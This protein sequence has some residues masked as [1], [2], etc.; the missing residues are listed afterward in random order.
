[1]APLE[2]GQPIFFR[3]YSSTSANDADRNWAGRALLHKRRN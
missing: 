1:M 3:M 2:A